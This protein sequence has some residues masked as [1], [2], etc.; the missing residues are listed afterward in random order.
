MPE[1]PMT[2]ESIDHFLKE[3]QNPKERL[4][5]WEL[6]FLYSVTTQFERKGTLSR[7]QF[8]VLERIYADKTA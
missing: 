6:D 2:P 5:Q 3:L 7:K 8:D 1:T 4:T